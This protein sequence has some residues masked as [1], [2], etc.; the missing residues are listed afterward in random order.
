MYAD[1]KKT[2]HTHTYL[3]IQQQKQHQQKWKKKPMQICGIHGHWVQRFT[4]G[5]PMH[6]QNKNKKKTNEWMNENVEWEK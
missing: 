5:Y 2:P 6:N 3:C 4:L 1:E